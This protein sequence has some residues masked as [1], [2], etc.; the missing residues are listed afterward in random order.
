MKLSHYFMVF[1]LVALTAVSCKNSKKDKNKEADP[2]EEM[3][4]MTE[5]QD[6]EKVVYK[7]ELAGLNSE[8]TGQETTGKAEFVVEGN[9]MKVTIDVKNAPPGM[10]HWQ[11]FH[12]FVNGDNA[13]CATASD[14]ENEDGIIDVIETESASG[15]TMVPFNDAPVGMQVPTDTYP[16]ADD[17]GNY[18][19]ES[20][21]LLEDLE[22][23]F[24]DAF[25][26]EDLQ[27][28]KRVLYIHGV[29]DGDL[30][31]SVESIGDIPAATTLPIACGKIEK[32]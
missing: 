29:S 9:T 7:V 18:H 31:D 19:Y 21:I 10:Q 26:D 8:V 2:A 5:D 27:L 16:E 3:E 6:S 4:A 28:D 13:K 12:G 30:P 15:T 1:A 24:A 25:N 11:H 23:A 17:D 22:T 14:D 32:Q 20:E